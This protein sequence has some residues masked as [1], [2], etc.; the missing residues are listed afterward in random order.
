M[1]V[2]LYLGIASALRPFGAVDPGGEVGCAASGERCGNHG[3]CV[4]FTLKNS[5][6][7]CEAGWFTTQ[8]GAEE[9]IACGVPRKNG[10]QA[11]LLQLFFGWA[12]VGAYYLGWTLWAS[13]QFIAVGGT[14]V[15]YCLLSCPTPCKRRKKAPVAP[16]L[17]P[18]AGPDGDTSVGQ[19]LG[20]NW[21]RPFFSEIHTTV[22]LPSSYLHVFKIDFRF[23]KT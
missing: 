18:D 23:V 12:S 15:L 4:D 2:L 16:L 10:L 19:T 9:G 13:A 17:A 11:F 22:R 5:T 7:E 20:A 6:C 3:S 21:V 14:C 1:L 8:A